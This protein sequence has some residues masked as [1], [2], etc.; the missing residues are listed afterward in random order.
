MF[1]DVNIIFYYSLI[2]K[3]LI[4]GRPFFGGIYDGK[5]S[6]AILAGSL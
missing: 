3:S 1:I 4:G 6:A 5:Q 2:V